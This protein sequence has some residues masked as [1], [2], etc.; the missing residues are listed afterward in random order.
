MLTANLETVKNKTSMLS[1]H[2][3]SSTKFLPFMS[4]RSLNSEF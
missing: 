1:T 4:R 2:K 3:I